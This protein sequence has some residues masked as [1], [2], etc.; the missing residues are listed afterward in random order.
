MVI[1]S[2]AERNPELSD[3]SA[4]IICTNDIPWITERHIFSNIYCKLGALPSGQ[5]VRKVTAV[6]FSSAI[7]F[8]GIIRTVD[9]VGYSLVKSSLS[10]WDGEETV[11][12]INSLVM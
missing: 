4:E 9:L 5:N 10:G 6:L 2:V 3:M 11:G 7:Q 12:A 1:F 8:T